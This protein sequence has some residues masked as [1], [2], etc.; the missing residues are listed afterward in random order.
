[1]ND[2]MLYRLDKTESDTFTQAGRGLTGETNHDT[3]NRHK[4]RLNF[5]INQGNRPLTDRQI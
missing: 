3:D 4:P 1:M 2:M 5:K